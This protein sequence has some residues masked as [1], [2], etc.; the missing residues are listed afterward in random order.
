MTRQAWTGLLLAAALAL[1]GSAHAQ[2]RDSVRIETI[3]VAPGVHMLI[4]DGGNIGVSSGPDGVLLIDGQSAAATEK[5]RAAVAAFS[6]RP[7]R[8]LLNTHWHGDHTGGNE[9]WANAGAVI[10]AHD[11]VRRR[12][13]TEQTIAGS[14]RK[15]PPAEMYMVLRV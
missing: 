2:G 15:V 1:T 9:N 6:D 12:M 5:I 11:N 14:G 3:P 7:V 13:S 10:V 8:F 4:G